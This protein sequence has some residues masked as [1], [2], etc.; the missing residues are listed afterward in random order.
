LTKRATLC[1]PQAAGLLAQ[2]TYFDNQK[3]RMNYLELREEG[4]LLGSGMIESGAKQFKARFT[5]PDMRWSREGIARLIPV[6]AAV[7]SHTFDAL[8]PAVYSFSKN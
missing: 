3:R 4:Y 7:L 2:A 8:W 1:P 5:G 6:R